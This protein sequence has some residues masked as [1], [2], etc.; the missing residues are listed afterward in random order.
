ML[1]VWRF[2]RCLLSS[3]VSLS[4]SALTTWSERESSSEKMSASFSSKFSAHNVAPSRPSTSWAVTRIRLRARWMLPSNNAST[5][6]SRPATVMSRARVYSRTALVGGTLIC[7]RLVSLVIS[8]SA[9]P[10]PTYSSPASAPIYLKGRTARD[11][12]PAPASNRSSL[13]LLNRARF[14]ATES[15]PPFD[16]SVTMATKR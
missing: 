4:D 15:T 1:S 16:A 13:L 5:F 7:L 12:T 2:T 3:P 9:S 10:S 6:S 11:L 14:A 8:A